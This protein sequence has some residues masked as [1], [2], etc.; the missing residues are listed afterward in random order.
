MALAEERTIPAK[1]QSGCGGRLASR[2]G[3]LLFFSRTFTF[4]DGVPQSCDQARLLLDAAARK[5][6]PGA[7]QRLTN[8]PSLGCQ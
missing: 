3:P 1:P 6:T 5:G 2:T 8:L 7:T 4:G